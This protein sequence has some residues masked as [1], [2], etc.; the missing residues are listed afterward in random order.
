MEIRKIN[1]R[2]SRSPDYAERGDFTS[3]FCRG[4]Q[5][6]SQRFIAHVHSYRFTHQ[7]LLGGVLVA[8]VVVVCLI[9]AP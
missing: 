1:R 2:R 4:Q 7:P 8:V 9:E 6:N 3:L 5:R